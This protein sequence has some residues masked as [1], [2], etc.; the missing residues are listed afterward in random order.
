MNYLD[1]KTNF[2]RT[3]LATGI[4]AAATSMTVDTGDGALFPATA[5]GDFNVIIWNSTDYPLVY[6]DPNKEIVRVTS[7]ATDVLTITRAQEGTSDVA[8]N[9]ALKTYGVVL[10]GTEKDREDTESSLQGETGTA[11]ASA[12]TTD[13]G[14]ST[15]QN[16]HITGTVTITGLGTADA[17]VFRRVEFDG[18]L[19][20]TYNATSLK[21]PGSATITTAAGDIAYC[22]SLGSG[23]WNVE[24]YS[25]KDGTSVVSDGGGSTSIIPTRFD[26]ID[27]ASGTSKYVPVG[28]GLE[29]ATESF[30]QGNFPA[31]TFKNMRIYNNNVWSGSGLQIILRKNGV[32]TALDVTVTSTG[33]YT[34]DASE[35]TVTA[36]D[37][38]NF[39]LYAISATGTA[40][41]SVV[42]EFVPD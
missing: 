42:I 5:E 34:V 3:T 21:L 41:I 36:T 27:V 9:T 4:A 32:D 24:T 26:N 37:E 30:S 29:Q 8:H 2:A 10:A 18:A 40:Y 15:G 38:V 11:I 12:T 19:T 14:V 6:D 31:G 16:V 28:G 20:L 1:P 7:R 23:N 17:G 33:T 13:I 22:V 39:R 35:V 25:K